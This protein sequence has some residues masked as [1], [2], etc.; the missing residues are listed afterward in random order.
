MRAGDEKRQNKI[1]NQ[2]KA[3]EKE[4]NEKEKKI[5]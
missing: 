5:Q 3:E 1:L 2:K 4:Q